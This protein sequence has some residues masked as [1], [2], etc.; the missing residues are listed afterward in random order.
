MHPNLDPLSDALQ[1][2]G[3]Y[4][5]RTLKSRELSRDYTLT[6]KLLYLTVVCKHGTSMW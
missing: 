6:V 1:A 3:S 5:S 2:K 4:E